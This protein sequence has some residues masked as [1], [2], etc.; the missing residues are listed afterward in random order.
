MDNDAARKIAQDLLDARERF[1]FETFGIE[2]NDEDEITII[3]VQS[4]KINTKN[5]R[6]SLRGI[7]N[8]VATIGAGSGNTCPMC[9][10]PR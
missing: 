1:Q 10:R 7:G 6:E 5:I 4:K 3:A 2:G 8:P 9:G